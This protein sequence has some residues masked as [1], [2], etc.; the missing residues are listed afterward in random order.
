M[1]PLSAILAVA[2]LAVSGADA[3]KKNKVSYSRYL[4]GDCNGHPM[5][6]TVF[7]IKLEKD[8][9]SEC[10][11]ITAGGIRF[12]KHR[13]DKYNHWIDD[14]N[15]GKWQ[16][17]A[18]I[19]K[20]YGCTDGDE[21]VTVSLP[22]ELQHCKP[23]ESLDASSVQFWCRP[24]T[25]YN[26]ITT[27]KEVELPVTSYS[28][29]ANGKAH[30]SLYTTTVVA[31][32]HHYPEQT[33]VPAPP[34]P[35]NSPLFKARDAP[36]RKASLEPRHKKH[37]KKGVWM[38]HPW[39]GSDICYMCYTEKESDYDKFKCRSDHR[40]KY[41]IKCGLKP[42]PVRFFIFHLKLTIVLFSL[43]QLS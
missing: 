34:I 10:K 13:K 8:G 17:G 26:G 36:T 32:E 2:L 41:F 25:G 4:G 12:H 38:K 22:Q 9:K 39:T 23:V 11:A 31:Y 1:A 27:H 43:E 24:N 37:N 6:G 19:Y 28:I 33:N 3:K 15:T 5:S 30:L 29:G 42:T 20:G 35:I 7:D 40:G 16:C 14:V 18:T 21:S